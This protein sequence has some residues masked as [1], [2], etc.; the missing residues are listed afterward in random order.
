MKKAVYSMLFAL[1]LLGCLLLAKTGVA[2]AKKSKDVANEKIVSTIGNDANIHKVVCL[3]TYSW[4]VTK[5]PTCCSTGTR[6][7]KCT[8][9][10]AR[11]SGTTV[12]TVPK[13]SANHSWKLTSQKESTC[14]TQGYKDYKC[15][16]CG[17]TKRD[18][19]A[20]KEHNYIVYTDYH[21]THFE[22][23]H[24][25]CQNCG[26]AVTKVLFV[27]NK[28]TN[29]ACIYF[30]SYALKNEFINEMKW[31]LEKRNKSLNDTYDLDN[32]ANYG[33]NWMLTYVRKCCNEM[34]MCSVRSLSYAY[35]LAEKSINNSQCPYLTIEFGIN[36][37]LGAGFGVYSVPSAI[38]IPGYWCKQTWK[39][40]DK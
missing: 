11:K 20:L 13:N 6:E 38:P 27:I 19:L 4:T 34:G 36:Y 35:T 26:T 29:S 7:C 5:A 1:T 25:K 21:A 12:E 3:H 14:K 23:V 22:D 30:P 16:L 8:K 2:S 37:T 10:G 31:Y 28:D 24:C 15:S 39:I 33:S 18:Y 32:K 17:K 40:L 9:C